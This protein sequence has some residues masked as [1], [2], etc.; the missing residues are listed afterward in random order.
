MKIIQERGGGEGVGQ[1]DG[2][3]GVS[4]KGTAEQQVEERDGR[5][6]GRANK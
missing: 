4:W 1:L 5:A 6:Q 3:G 2:V